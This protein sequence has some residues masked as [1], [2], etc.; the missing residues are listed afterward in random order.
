MD[1]QVSEEAVYQADD[2]GGYNM[3]SRIIAPPK[4]MVVPAKKPATPAKKVTVPPKKM[5]IIP[6]QL[7][8]PIHSPTSN[9]VQLKSPVHEVRFR[10]RLHSSFN[11]E[12]EIQKL[13]IHFPL[14]EQ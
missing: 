14:I 4:K 5:A 3:K 13:K 6:K 2:Q 7:Q 10:D 1:D 11:L 8:N 12:S 9:P